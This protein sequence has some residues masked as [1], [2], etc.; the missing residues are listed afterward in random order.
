[1]IG[2]TEAVAP[3]YKPLGVLIYSVA[4]S[5]DPTASFGANT[6]K[7]V[8]HDDA[9]LVSLAKRLRAQTIAMGE[10]MATRGGSPAYPK[11]AVDRIFRCVSGEA[12]VHN[13]TGS[14]ANMLVG[15]MGQD[16]RQAFLDHV[17]AMLIPAAAASRQ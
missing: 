14:D 8:N 13:P 12:P 15:M 6:N 4:L 16:K 3:E 17:D 1:M 9:Q 10:Q 11:E 5:A 7:R 2:L